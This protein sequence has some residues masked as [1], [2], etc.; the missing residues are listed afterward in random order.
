M[1][2]QQQ[3]NQGGHVSDVD[4]SVAINVSTDSAQ[5]AI[6]AQQMV[7]ERGHVGDVDMWPVAP[8][9]RVMLLLLLH[10]LQVPSI[11]KALTR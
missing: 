11:Y 3:V 2:V 6:G 4:D 7:D 8:S 1:S 9:C 10:G 5:A